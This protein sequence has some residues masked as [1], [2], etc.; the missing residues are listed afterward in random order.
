MSQ[1]AAA[2]FR[3]ST[4]P[5]DTVGSAFRNTSLMRPS[6]TGS[7]WKESVI[8]FPIRAKPYRSPPASPAKKPVTSSAATR[9]RGSRPLTVVFRN[10]NAHSGAALNETLPSP[11][12]TIH[13]SKLQEPTAAEYL[14]LPFPPVLASSHNT[15]IAHDKE[16]RE[17]VDTCLE[18]Y[19]PSDNRYGYQ[20]P[21]AEPTPPHTGDDESTE[22][23]SDSRP[24]STLPPCSSNSSLIDQSIL[25]PSCKDP[26]RNHFHYK[27]DDEEDPQSPEKT[28][29]I[30]ALEI[31]SSPTQPSPHTR[32]ISPADEINHRQQQ[33]PFYPNSFL[34]CA[35]N[36]A[37]SPSPLLFTALRL[38][39]PA[40][41]PTLLG[42]AHRP[43][44]RFLQAVHPRP[45]DGNGTA[46]PQ[47]RPVPFSAAGGFG[48]P[49]LPLRP[50]HLTLPLRG[51]NFPPKNASVFPFHM[52][53][54]GHAVQDTSQKTSI[55][56]RSP[57]GTA[58][59]QAASG[60]NRSTSDS[61]G[62]L[63]VPRRYGRK[64]HLSS[65]GPLEV[66]SARRRRAP[67]KPGFPTLP[68]WRGD[69]TEAGMEEAVN[70]RLICNISQQSSPPLLPAIPSY[71]FAA[72]AQIA[73]RVSEEGKGVYLRPSG[74]V[75]KCSPNPRPLP[76]FNS[77]V[78]F[79]S[80]QRK[81][82]T[83]HHLSGTTPPED[84]E[85]DVAGSKDVLI[86]SRHVSVPV[87]TRA[88]VERALTCSLMPV[89]QK[90]LGIVDR[91]MGMSRSSSG[92]GSVGSPAAGCGTP[93][94]TTSCS[95]AHR[96][97]DEALLLP[98]AARLHQSQEET[99]QE[100]AQ[101]TGSYADTNWDC[102]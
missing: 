98:P 55:T 84:S 31:S 92:C 93:S 16:G 41:P 75:R 88:F 8:G 47:G 77:R 59:N 40:A 46:T 25:S 22:P 66:F 6:P 67:R 102:L 23:S 21:P 35:P 54:F 12:P 100:N 68:P 3:L 57:T 1:A 7:S 17:H 65:T 82:R 19:E 34:H 91:R 52:P 32:R 87:D 58:G 49:T 4:T 89:T 26:S 44:H 62:R 29:A 95:S 80:K 71:D 85:T 60:S 61:T 79:F 78:R 74:G 94:T 37:S 73:R 99:V 20:Y 36:P 64:K 24:C 50:P 42:H 81:N 18:K 72:Y 33:S 76:E 101:C 48:L 9:P 90:R 70:C 97:I 5:K 51:A 69:V 96:L 10:K 27:S 39:G 38:C 53:A 2:V 83:A 11:S 56:L 28:D 13:M 14:R 43:Q 30:R 15:V 86:S 45:Q 63:R